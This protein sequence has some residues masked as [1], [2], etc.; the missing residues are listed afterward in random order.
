MN[1]TVSRI[2]IV[3]CY[4]SGAP[5]ARVPTRTAHRPTD[6]NQKLEGSQMCRKENV[7]QPETNDLK[8]NPAGEKIDRSRLPNITMISETYGVGRLGAS[9]A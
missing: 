3:P 4:R 5:A 9:V 8:R 2:Q 6:Y 1:K 7:V